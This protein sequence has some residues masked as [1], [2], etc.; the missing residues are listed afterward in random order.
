MLVAAVF[1]AVGVFI[2]VRWADEREFAST[3]LDTWAETQAVVSDLRAVNWTSPSEDDDTFTV[4]FRLSLTFWIE[5]A[6]VDGYAEVQRSGTSDLVIAEGVERE[7]P[8][9][10]PTVIVYNP[11]RP[12]EIRVGSKEQIKAAANSIAHLVGGCLFALFGLA[13][14]GAGARSLIQSRRAL[15][16]P[17]PPETAA[18]EW[19]Q[20]YPVAWNAPQPVHFSPGSGGGR[21]SGPET[22]SRPA[23]PDPWPG[24]GWEVPPPFVQPARGALRSYG[25]TPSPDAVPPFPPSAPSA[26]G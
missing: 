2:A 24:T 7:F 12:E 15:K 19:P 10:Q 9:G 25:Q 26:N 6:K 23:A 4:T 21:A 5:D 20:P 22:P 17:D 8:E 13:F 16:A 11:E 14:M 1:V 18:P 3:T